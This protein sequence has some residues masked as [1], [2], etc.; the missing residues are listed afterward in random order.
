MRAQRTRL[1]RR[2]CYSY[3]PFLFL[4]EGPIAWVGF[5]EAESWAARGHRWSGAHQDMALAAGG[6]GASPGN[7][8]ICHS[9]S[10]TN[11]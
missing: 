2:L 1:Q 5:G 7:V 3:S 4:A 11:N 6:N 10:F 9:K 8:A